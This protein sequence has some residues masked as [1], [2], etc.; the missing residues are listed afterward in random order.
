MPFTPLKVIINHHSSALIGPQSCVRAVQKGRVPVS[1]LH[2]CGIG[3][4]M[5]AVI[6]RRL[7]VKCSCGSVSTCKA[8]ASHSARRNPLAHKTQALFPRIQRD[9]GVL[10]LH[11]RVQSA[12]AAMQTDG[13]ACL[14]LP[15]YDLISLSRS[16]GPSCHLVSIISE[17]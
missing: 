9:L 17:T 11:H 2:P 13:L 15:A 10:E 16:S 6:S 5:S 1:M 8:H 3:L 7:L 4:Y 12:I 14:Y